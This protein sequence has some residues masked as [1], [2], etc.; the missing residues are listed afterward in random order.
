MAVASPV[1]S[2]RVPFF[3]IWLAQAGSLLGSSIVQFALVWWLMLQ[4][5]SATILAMASLVG[6]LPTILLGPFAGSM[7]DRLNR[8]RVMIFADAGI[9]VATALLG[10]IYFLGWMQ[11]WHVYV[12]LFVRAIGGTFHWPAMQ[13]ST[14][15]LVPKEQLSRISG[16]N[17][18]LSGLMSIIS[19]PLGA[20]V[21]SVLP[22]YGAMGI[23]VLTALIAI[24][25]LLFIAIPQSQI[26]AAPP[27]HPVCTLLRDV[28]G[29]FAMWRAGRVC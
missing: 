4:T 25:T 16:M 23:D 20:L 7:V 6:I 21:V 27:G 24:T 15:M 18:T 10:A 3:T 28:A 1:K 9:A 12:I 8:R 5:R 19:P 13:A 17:Q 11:A 14:T 29:V 2:W 22:L 26:S